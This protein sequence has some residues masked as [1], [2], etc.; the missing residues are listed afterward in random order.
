MYGGSRSGT[1]PGS[2]GGAPE[3]K[4]P[5]N[6]MVEGQASFLVWRNEYMLNINGQMVANY[7]KNCA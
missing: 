6:F 4:D 3:D 1:S 5:N 2:K 7:F